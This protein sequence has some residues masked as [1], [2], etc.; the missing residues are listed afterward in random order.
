MQF[1]LSKQLGM[2]G[3]ELREEFSAVDTKNMFFLCLCALG[4]E[5]T[6]PPCTNATRFSSLWSCCCRLWVS[7]GKAVVRSLNVKS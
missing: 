2:L 1:Y 7:A 5:K 3:Q 6:G 4:R